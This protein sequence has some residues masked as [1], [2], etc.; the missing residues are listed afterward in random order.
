VL[1]EV[2]LIRPTLL[3][4]GRIRPQLADVARSAVRHRWLFVV[5]LAAVAAVPF[6]AEAPLNLKAFAFHGSQIV[7]GNFADVYADPWNQSG[8]LQLLLCYVMFAAMPNAL[9][10][11]GVH[12]VGNIAVIL[13]L[14]GGSRGLRLLDELPPIPTV[15][16]GLGITAVVWLAPVRM[17]HAHPAELVIPVLWLAAGAA[18]Y[19][20]SWLAA[21]GL[22]GL[23]AGWEPWAMLAVPML[24]I[25][26]DPRKVLRSAAV[27]LALIVCSYLPFAASGSFHLFDH[28]WPVV[29]GTPLNHLFPKLTEV[30]WQVRV[31]QAA[32]S[33]G[34]CTLVVLLL[35]RTIAVVSLA[36]LAAV[37]VRFVFD[38]Y[39]IDYYWV[40][41]TV[42][43]FAG[44]CVLSK[45]STQ[46]QI[47]SLIALAGLSFWTDGR[48]T[49]EVSIGILLLI[50]AV[51]AARRGAASITPT[52]NTRA[53]IESVSQ[54][55]SRC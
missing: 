36:P 40:A 39:I 3:W 46:L 20:G 27:C 6:H 8:P 30:T 55:A 41:V 17:W 16:L 31:L 37:L 19:R 53:G 18:A 24:L 14:R 9:G 48:L 44:I 49:A 5:I 50:V 21:G 32:A 25:L 26:R 4:H 13:L 29:Q 23:A 33:T 51:A 34:A 2:R 7:H 47:V 38:P 22:F 35:R 52:A 15:E 43:T 12:M 1:G 45:R 10:A 11:V 54:E 42:L 28:V